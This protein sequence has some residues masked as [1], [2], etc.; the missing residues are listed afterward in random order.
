MTQRLN[1]QLID[2]NA[3]YKIQSGTFGNFIIAT[4]IR[5]TYATYSYDLFVVY[6]SDPVFRD[7]V[8][9]YASIIA[10]NVL[11]VSKVDITDLDNLILNMVE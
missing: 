7:T 3:Y 10:D 9:R 6:T 4:R 8:N 11:I 2:Y 1:G 5:Q